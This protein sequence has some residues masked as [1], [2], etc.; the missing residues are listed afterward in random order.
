MKTNAKQSFIDSK[1]EMTYQ[2]YY[3][4]YGQEVEGNGETLIVYKNGI[5]IIKLQTQEYY[6]IIE[7]SEYISDSLSEIENILWEGFAKTELNN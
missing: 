3:N 5:Y 4:E 2:E 1:R 6:T 7:R